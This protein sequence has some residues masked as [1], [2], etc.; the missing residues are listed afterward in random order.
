MIGKTA[1]DRGRWE[2]LRWG[3]KRWH[4]LDYELKKQYGRKVYKLSLQTGCSCPNRDGTLGTGGCIFCSEGGS[5]DFAASAALPVSEQIRAAKKQ[6]AA[7]VPADAGYIAYFQS[8]TNTYGPVERLK[9]L[10][11]AAAG[12]PDILELSIATRPD[13][14]QEEMLSML[15]ELGKKKPV[16]IELG[17]QTIHEESAA[18]IRR[19]YTLPVFE[20]AVWR[21]K[22]AGLSVTVHLI[23]GLPGESREQIRESVRYLTEL[24]RMG[25]GIDGI[26]L[27]L[28][29]ILKGTA[30][31]DLYL[32]GR[33]T[34]K[35]PEIRWNDYSMEEYVDLVIDLIEFLPPELVVH[36][37]TG[38]APKRLL[39]APLWS[40][41]KKRVLNMFEKR[42]RER[43]TWQGKRC[44]AG[45]F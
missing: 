18:F 12:E 26:K 25:A 33:E 27:Q 42:F 19:G 20:D 3:E 37:I 15:A 28:L 32:A 2:G 39:I 43:N 36:R 22:R 4:S 9:A 1:E 44:A 7:K 24:R 45:E 14:L 6:I 40:A 21:L 35:E 38:D 34:E 8:F 11:E 31:G 13:C 16:S 10:Y 41:D 5:G 23:V 17:L 29:H 30:L